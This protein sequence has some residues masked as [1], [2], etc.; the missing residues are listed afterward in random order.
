MKSTVVIILF[1]QLCFTG[2]T[3]AQEKSKPIRAN[4]PNVTINDGW[5]GKT[6][7]FFVS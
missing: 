7:W 5:E 2:T 6:K 1:L 3:F 4:S